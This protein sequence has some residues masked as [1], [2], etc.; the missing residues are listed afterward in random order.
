MSPDIRPE[1]GIHLPAQPRHDFRKGLDILQ[2][3]AKVDDTHSQSKS[4]LYHCVREEGLATS[5]QAG[6]HGASHIPDMYESGLLMG[7][8]AQL[9]GSTP[10]L[11]AAL[12]R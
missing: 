3:G 12:I 11:P 8:P 6:Q 2:P 5:F 7:P 9:Q 4:A 10:L 1:S